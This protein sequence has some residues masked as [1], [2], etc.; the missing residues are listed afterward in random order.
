MKILRIWFKNIN[1]LEGESQ[2]DF[3]QAPFSDTGVFAITGPNGSGKSSILDAI[4]LGLYGETFRFDRP[5]SHVMTKQTA[6]CFAEVEFSVDQNKYRSSWHVERENGNLDGKLTPAKMQLL[7]LGDTQEL[8]ANNLQQV[9][10]RIAE[11]T[12]MNF[13]NFTRSI[14]LAQGD[15]AAFLNALDS[16]RMDVLEKII[17]TDIYADY[18]QEI[19][20]NAAVAQQRLQELTQDLA[21]VQ[22]LPPERREAC[23]HDLIDFNDQCAE[24]Q[25][26]QDQ[27]KKQ[28]KILQSVSVLQDQLIVSQKHLSETKTTAELHQQSLAK[29]QKAEDIQLFKTDIDELKDKTQT[30]QQNKATL[31][32]FR[33]EL[34]Q[35]QQ[36]LGANPTPPVGFDKLGVTEQLQLIDDIK[37]QLSLLNSQRNSETSLLQ[38][39]AV[40]I[41]EKKSVL[42]T[43]TTWLEEHA[44]DAVLVD[45]FPQLAR[46]RLVRSEL[47]ELK[48]QYKTSDKSSKTSLA[49]LKNSKV[50]VEKELKQCAA[51]MQELQA[52]EK[53]LEILG[54]GNN[55][56]QIEELRLELQ[57]RTDAFKE[58]NQLAVHNQK[59]DKSKNGFF[60]RLFGGRKPEL[61]TEEL[62]LELDRLKQDLK[63]EENIKLALESLV[64]QESLVKKMEA[65]R[66][67]L[68]DGKPCPLC[69]ALEHPYSKTIPTSAN[70]KQALA[71]QQA[72]L[73]SLLGIVDRLAKDLSTAQKNAQN[74]QER[75]NQLIIIRSQWLTL[76]NRL[77]A[78]GHD[79]N[80]TNLKSMKQLHNKQLNELKEVT[81]L[82]S[83]FISTQ[84]KID[85]TKAAITKSETTIGQ[86]QQ[87]I[88]Q[89][90]AEWQSRP[91]EINYEDVL[92]AKQLEE[93]QLSERVIEQLTA[94]GEKMPT[95]K[96]EDA[97]LDRLNARR[98]EFQSYSL[99]RKSLT[100]EIDELV[101]KEK[102][103]QLEI[104]NCNGKMDAC[105][106]QLQS[107]EV[108]GLHLAIIEKQKLIADKEQ[109][110]IQQQTE[111]VQKQ[112][113]LQEKIQVSQFSHVEEISELLELIQNQ[114][115]IE[116]KQVELTQ[117]AQQYAEEVTKINAQL[118][119]EQAR[120]KTDLTAQDLALKLKQVNEQLDIARLEAQRL[121]RLLQDQ[122]QLQQKYDAAL[123]Q[124]Q[125]QQKI[126]EQCQSELDRLSAESG[127]EFRRRVQTQIADKLLSQ[128]NT[129]LEKISGRYYL[130]QRFSD[131]GL[132]LEIEDT[133]QNNVRRL[134]K[135]L[136]GGES[137]V[138]SL[139][140][141]LGLAE[142]AN[143]GKSVDSLFLDEGF[144]NLD[145]ETLYTVI[146]TLEN[147]HTQHGK[148]VGVISHVESVQKRFK[149]QLQVVKKPNGMGE[150]KKAS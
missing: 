64:F 110:L 38:A 36:S 120:L 9:C 81:S 46:L 124:L 30:L 122:Q 32:S 99:R 45:D 68:A 131:Q 121:E 95:Q 100:E 143:N 3:Q 108:A 13:R 89:L 61:S 96:K 14:L 79:L 140:L 21:V 19:V 27:L 23:E 103:S 78:A 133:L 58:L 113:A 72:K 67:H 90:D 146:S 41:N 66:H 123:V 135:T 91:E 40:Q 82:K 53:D 104:K 48:Q 102:R 52:Q 43:T 75:Q 7:R 150:L 93:K 127:N 94:L 112:Q 18:K 88:Q 60:G 107:E 5:A 144:G 85:K 116:Q 147:L 73:K 109:L 24:L 51:L 71:D 132:A 39:L 12:G 119:A 56:Q 129:V 115:D 34:T 49:T 59:L 114:S 1:S 62:S 77:G 111:L 11:I 29:I 70:S 87:S 98:Q 118:Q 8:L 25:Q 83:K 57:D 63:R 105:S 50:A 17:S 42:T 128:T 35:L 149:A 31:A 65:D 148:T 134:P 28:Q 69:G 137:F 138:V 6:E 44:N 16:E 47:V 10:A 15:F 117:K 84:A 86:L 54:Q 106:I 20:D 33:A 76:C 22:V 141:A 101:A 92:M 97:L 139:A 126:T 125:S 2:I 37:V 55:L 80:I 130:R 142:L 26:E 136:S 74:D 145:S 4:T